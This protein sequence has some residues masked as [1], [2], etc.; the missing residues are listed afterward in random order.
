MSKRLASE[1]ELP[2]EQ[3]SKRGVIDL[4]EEPDTPVLAVTA[5]GT[6]VDLTEEEAEA[7]EAE[8]VGAEEEDSSEDDG[9]DDVEDDGEEEDDDSSESSES[10][11]DS[12]AILYADFEDHK[13][14]NDDFHNFLSVFLDVARELFDMTFNTV[15][16]EI[17]DK[18]EGEDTANK[19]RA[20]MGVMDED[21]ED[22][23]GCVG[24]PGCE[25]AESFFSKKEIKNVLD[26][27][28]TTVC[29]ELESYKSA[30]EVTSM[31]QDV[32]EGIE[33]ARLGK[34]IM[35]TFRVP[36]VH[37]SLNDVVDSAD[38]EED[39][40]LETDFRNH[41][42]T[43]AE[44]GTFLDALVE[45]VH[46]HYDD[47]DESPDDILLEISDSFGTCK[48]KVRAAVLL[49]VG[50]YKDIDEENGAA[51]VNTSL[52]KKQIAKFLVNIR[53]TFSDKMRAYRSA[54][55]LKEFFIALARGIADENLRR[56]VAQAFRVRL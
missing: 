23:M 34:K 26:A 9:E 15:M 52:T 2:L 18:I 31:F 28:F 16:S 12:D 27:I 40:I 11:V 21:S 32:A 3:D 35:R 8:E 20:V 48:D 30:H 38:E 46:E 37:S 6:L 5:P 1:A 14:S 54:E 4:T 22:H 50:H 42:L 41:G 55:E 51:G 13:L 25:E 24:A 49:G 39:A 17:C 43:E 7:E 29:D 56:K 19:A 53:D 10:S 47:E 36:L 33:D 45:K 44:F